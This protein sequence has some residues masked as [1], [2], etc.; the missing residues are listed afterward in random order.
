MTPTPVDP[1]RD[2]AHPRESAPITITLDGREVTGRSGQTVAGMILAA[3]I[4][5][6]RRTSV[7][8]APRGVFCGIG[9]CFDCIV[10][11][12]GL[13]DVRAC[14]RRARDGDV[15][16]AQHDRLPAAPAQHTDPS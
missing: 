15:V 6:W 1:G 16:V 11:V 2:P 7:G 10:T 12:N 3:G 9:V 4:Q 13:R 14:L 5:Q 8:A